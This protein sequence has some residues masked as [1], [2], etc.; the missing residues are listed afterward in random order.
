MKS[1][2][3]EK[4]AK[5]IIERVNSLSEK[6]TPLWGKMDVNGMLCH[7]S[8]TLR[9]AAGT[10][11]P[12]FV[13]SA[14]SA[15]PIKWLVLAGMPTP[16]GKVETVKE[17]KQGAGGTPPTGLENDKAIFAALLN[18][19]ERP[20][21]SGKTFCHPAFGDMTKKQWARLAYLHLN[22]HLKQF[23]K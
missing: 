5:V 17:M 8:D 11:H 9:M 3:N 13:G 12:A 15:G 18:N 7:I 23:G 16:K 4:T 10:I 22:Y 2:L 1:L 14:L 20:F 19:F 21:E 6:D